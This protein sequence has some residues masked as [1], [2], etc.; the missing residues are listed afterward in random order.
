MFVT[1]PPGRR[2]DSEGLP[3]GPGPQLGWP[4]T[5]HCGSN[6]GSSMSIMW[7][8]KEQQGSCR[9]N[10]ETPTIILLAILEI[11][12]A[13]CCEREDGNYATS[14][15]SVVY[16]WSYKKSIHLLPDI[17][18]VLVS[19]HPDFL[20]SQIRNKWYPK[21]SVPPRLPEETAGIRPWRSVEGGLGSKM[22]GVAFFCFAKCCYRKMKIWF[23]PK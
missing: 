21:T 13:D 23:I 14:V 8:N 20:Q 5:D 9:G 4:N 17:L 11:P 18:G 3:L 1:L 12:M 16:W 10:L 7:A 22:F 15:F 19:H 6:W 2:L